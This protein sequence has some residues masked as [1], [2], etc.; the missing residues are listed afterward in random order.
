[1]DFNRQVI[2]EFRA[3]HG[4][5]GGM[6]EGVPL[7]LLTTQG[8]RSDA[9][10]TNPVVY[11]R[12]GARILVFASNAGAPDHPAWYHNLRAYPQV[13]V[14]IGEGDGI[15]TYATRAEPLE[16]AERD[17]CYREQAERDPAFAEYARKTTR[18]I[19]VIA[20]HP[21]SLGDGGARVEAVGAQL[22]RHHEELR[23]EFARLRETLAAGEIPGTPART[24]TEHCLTFCDHLDLH[25]IREN[26]AF[27]A[28]ED[29]FPELRP[30]L[31]RLRAEHHVVAQGLAEIRAVLAGGADPD[32]IG[33]ALARVTEGLEEHFA[34]EEASLFPA[35]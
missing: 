1:M 18:V 24:L 3:N 6:F 11:F 7:I 31:A 14:E 22:R 13:T 21:L 28:F 17:R 34:Y 15:R 16:G 23:A 2:E 4:R 10:R 9:P 25:H 27:T 30:A 26:G 12:D 19:P 20:L 5:V 35:A 29:S 8:A 32:K 33:A